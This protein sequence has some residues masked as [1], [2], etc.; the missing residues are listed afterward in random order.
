MLPKDM[1][2]SHQPAIDDILE[3]ASQLSPEEKA[4]LIE[5]LLL[6]SGIVCGFR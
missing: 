4:Q 3:Q 6:Y 5:R 1:G 2:N